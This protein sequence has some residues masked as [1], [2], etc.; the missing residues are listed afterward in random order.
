M[1]IS[2]IIIF[3]FLALTILLGVMAQRGKDVNLE[4][5]SVGGR[6]F[7]TIFV[8]LLMAGEI[9]TTFT[10]LGGSGWA[11]GKGGPTFYIIGYGCLAYIL[12]YWMLPAIWR[13]SS[14]MKLVSQS[15]F[16]VSKYNSKGLGIIVAIVGVVAMLPYLVLQFTG[17]GLI[18]NL[19]SYG[20]ISPAWAAVIGVV[21]VTTY[22]MIS[23]I[24]GS[25][26]TAVLKDI[27][28]LGIVLFLGIY[29]PIHYYGDLGSMFQ[30]IEVAKPGFTILPEAGRSIPW[31]I[32][33]VLLTALG[34][35]MWPH[36]FGSVYSA[37]NVRVF[38]KNAIFMPLYQLI[39]LFVFFVGFAAILQVPGL[40]GS[41]AD[42]S[43]ILLSIQTFDPWLVGLIGAAGLLTAIVPG[44]MILMAASTLIAKNIVKVVAPTTTDQKIAFY[45]KCI[46][47]I[48]A[49][50]CLFFTIQGTQTIVDLLIIGYGIVTQL[51]PPLVMSLTKKN[52][53]TKFGAMAGIIAGCSISLIPFFDKTV[54]NVGVLIPSLPKVLGDLNL[55]VVALI[56]NL[57][58]M[59]TVS[60][61]TNGN[62]QT[63]VAK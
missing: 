32:S 18:V 25:A 60:F 19:T 14:K 40:V 13:Y 44:S 22:V 55:G 46:V 63:Q 15:D 45:A 11:Y 27:M 9:Y 52:F 17:L 57:V 26:W 41:E 21:A 4:Q 23:G 47:P 59:F 58:V 36:T 62:R 12:S 2:L 16:F 10:F 7:G 24:H 42:K 49:G 56:V 3:G 50:I 39:L 33:T 43:L 6:G 34:F 35:Y 1:N 28:I 29:L 61:V 38:R 20:K 54:I 51:F 31:F 5:W 48:F 53:V 30:A 8:F 37:K